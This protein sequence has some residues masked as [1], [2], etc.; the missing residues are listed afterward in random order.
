MKFNKFFVRS[1]FGPI[2][3]DAPQKFDDKLSQ[4]KLFNISKSGPTNV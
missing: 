3:Y 4:T 1:V 2:C